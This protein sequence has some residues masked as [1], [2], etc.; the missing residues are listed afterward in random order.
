MPNALGGHQFN[1]LFA[2]RRAWTCA[3]ACERHLAGESHFDIQLTNLPGETVRWKPFL[4]RPGIKKRPIDDSSFHTLHTVKSDGVV[5][6]S[7]GPFGSDRVAAPALQ[8]AHVPEQIREPIRYLSL[9]LE[10]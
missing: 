9:E 1:L 4:H 7:T 3:E 10:N 8:A 6:I 2:K 5:D